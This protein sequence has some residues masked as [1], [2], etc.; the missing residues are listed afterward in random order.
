M[1]ISLLLVDD[2]K[3]VRQ[4]LRFF[5]QS[6]EG[7]SVLGEAETENEAVSQFITLQP[8][9]VLMDLQLKSGDGI[10]AT[11][12]ILTESPNAI[13]IVVTS[14]SD[15]DYVIPALQAGAKGYQ[16][17]DVDP[18][19]LAQTIF[20]AVQGGNAIHPSVMNHVLSHMTSEKDQ[21][22]ATL[23]ERELGVLI[24]ISTGRSNKEIALELQISELTV[25]T[26]VS[27]LLSKLGVQDRTQAAL[28]AI[29]VGVAKPPSFDV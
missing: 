6:V 18:E 14:F 12:R 16:L 2:H 10:Q 7:I 22:L 19:E 29:Q 28:F 23:T 21:R 24:E 15:Q 9:V 25:K 3:I 20:A 17:K 26:H 8:D 11:K 4:G 27:R 1:S 13:I 5:F